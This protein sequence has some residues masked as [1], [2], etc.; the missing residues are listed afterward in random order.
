[1]E[2]EWISAQEAAERWNITIRQVQSLCAKGKINGVMR[3]GRAWLIP[4]NAP[5][6]I[7]GRTKIAK[8]K[9]ENKK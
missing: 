4:K 1:M 7:D 6:P 2:L 3:F 8:Q 9:K 5:R